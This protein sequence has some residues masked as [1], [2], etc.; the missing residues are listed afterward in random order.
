[1]EKVQRRHQVVASAGCTCGSPARELREAADWRNAKVE[2]CPAFA[3]AA[4]RC[5]FDI[6]R[7]AGFQVA[8]APRNPKV[9]GRVDDLCAANAALP[10]VHPKFFGRA[11]ALGQALQSRKPGQRLFSMQHLIA[12][13]TLALALNHRHPV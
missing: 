6:A 8:A 13:R 12:N 5:V 1:M 9:L 10:R 4:A 11:A 3:A 2:L 7:L